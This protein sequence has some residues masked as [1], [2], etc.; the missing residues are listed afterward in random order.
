M[1]INLADLSS[2]ASTLGSQSEEHAGP[3]LAA[4][5][6]G[7][8]ARL[9]ELT[10][11]EGGRLVSLETRVRTLAE[12]INSSDDTERRLRGLRRIVR[13]RAVSQITQYNF[14]LLLF[15]RIYKHKHYSKGP[16]KTRN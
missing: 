1:N 2:L 11:E 10:S 9:A 6:E 5:L 4:R 14:R 8:E 3:R 15:H 7:V 13:N 16:V 12:T